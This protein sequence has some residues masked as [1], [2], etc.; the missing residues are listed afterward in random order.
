MVKKTILN[1]DLE[2]VLGHF[3]KYHTKI[4]LGDFHAKVRR[5]NTFKWDVGVCIGSS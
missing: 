5:E 2:Q 1:E 4:L 3:L